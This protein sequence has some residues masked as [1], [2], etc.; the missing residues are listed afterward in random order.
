MRVHRKCGKCGAP[1]KYVAG[2]KH[3]LEW[4]E[5]EKHDAWDNLAQV[6]RVSLINIKTWFELRGLPYP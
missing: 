2:D 1:A 6:E 3:G 5:C 4:F